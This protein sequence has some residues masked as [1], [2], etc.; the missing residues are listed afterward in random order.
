MDFADAVELIGRIA[1]D[2][3]YLLKCAVGLEPFLDFVFTVFHIASFG[4]NK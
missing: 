2:V 1:E 4:G 3:P